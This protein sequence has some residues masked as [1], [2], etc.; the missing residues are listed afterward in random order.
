MPFWELFEWRQRDKFISEHGR[1]PIGDVWQASLLQVNELA[2]FNAER[3]VGEL[4]ELLQRVAY[5]TRTLAS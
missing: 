5:S 3:D 1:D 4:V 2:L